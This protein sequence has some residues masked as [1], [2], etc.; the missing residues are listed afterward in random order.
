MASVNGTPTAKN[1]TDPG[2]KSISPLPQGVWPI[3]GA[4][5]DVPARAEK[6]ALMNLSGKGSL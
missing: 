5:V 3:D 6:G 2:K 4:Y 1:C